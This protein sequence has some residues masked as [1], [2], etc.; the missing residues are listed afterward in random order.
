MTEY[1]LIMALILSV[2]VAVAA[3]RVIQGF[4]KVVVV[5]MAVVSIALGAAAFLVMTDANDFRENLGSGRNLVVVADD[6]KALFAMELRGSNGSRVINRQ[7]VDEYSKKIAAGD[8]AAVR[9]GYYKLII[10]STAIIEGNGTKPDY[11][12]E[13]DDFFISIA[14]K[15]FSDPVFFI[16]EYKKGSIKVYEETALFRALGMMPASL[17]KS[18]AGK[19]IA[20]AKIAVVDKIEG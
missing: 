18:A 7:E 15:V 6:D 19:A 20:K 10:I 1:A 14:E 16:S 12:A 2:I 13:G 4:L 11:S 5:V 17:V 3:Y 8:Y 9:D